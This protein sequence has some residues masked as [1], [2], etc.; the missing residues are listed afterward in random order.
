MNNTEEDRAQRVDPRRAMNE[1]AITNEIE[2]SVLNKSHN[3]TLS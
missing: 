2:I 1:T 3:E